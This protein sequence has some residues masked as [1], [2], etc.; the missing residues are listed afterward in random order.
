MAVKASRSRGIRPVRQAWISGLVMLAIITLVVKS[1]VDMR[2]A[3]ASGSPYFMLGLFPALLSPLAF[4]YYLLKIPVVLAMRR[5]MSAIAR[6]TVSADEFRQFL[7][8]DTR[9]ASET[10]SPNYFAPAGTIPM[11][12]LEVIFSNDGV[13][14][15]DGYFPLS[16]TRGRRVNRVRSFGSR[17]PMIEF[18]TILETRARTSSVTTKAV[19]TAETLRVPVAS[20]AVSQA[21]KVVRHF[22]LAI[23][24]R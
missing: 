20:D 15:G 12:G 9:V 24:G 16:T 1:I 18:G 8:A 3:G 11:E 6:W 2:A 7:D 5:G 13:L 23:A 10:R 21:E 22:E 4:V 19:R 17:P 14:I